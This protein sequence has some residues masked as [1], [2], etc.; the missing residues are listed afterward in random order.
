MNPCQV[1]IFGREI[2]IRDDEISNPNWRIKYR[3]LLK[4]WLAQKVSVK[5]IF[6]AK[7]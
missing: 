1:R 4:G 2:V 6:Y 3:L 5:Y 7:I